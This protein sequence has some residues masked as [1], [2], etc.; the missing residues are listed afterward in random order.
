M[1]RLAIVLM[2]CF[3]LFLQAQLLPAV[4]HTNWIPNAVLTAVIVITVFRG[5]S[6][7]LATAIVGGGLQD[8][9]ISNFF[10]LHLFSYSALVYILSFVQQRVYEER[11]YWTCIIVAIGTL[12]DGM[13]RIAIIAASGGN[14]YFFAYMWHMIIPTVFWNVLLGAVG[15]WLLQRKQEEENYFW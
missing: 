3:L 11:W 6:A 14:I 1:R 4:F 8:I 9:L 7:G 15:H 5:Q 13:M 2:G 12:L 10:G